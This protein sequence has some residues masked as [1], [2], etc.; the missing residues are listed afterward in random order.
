M[1]NTLRLA[2]ELNKMDEVPDWIR[3]FENQN[4]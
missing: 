2:K 1:E 4:N 3:K